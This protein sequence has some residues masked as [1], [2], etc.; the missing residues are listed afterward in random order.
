M[1]ILQATDCYPPPLLG[2]RDVHV[3]MLTHELARRGHDVEVV[4]LSGRAGARVESDGDV[5]V[6]RV[7][8]WSRALSRFYEDPSRIFHP[9]VPDPGLVLPLARLIRQRRPD[10]V[11]A[12]SWIL[13]S[14]LP[15]L[16][17]T[18]TRLVVT[19]HDYGLVCA[20][21]SF[22][23]KGGVCEGPSYPKC[24]ACA[25]GQYGAVRSAAITT[26]L[27]IMHRSHRRVDRYIAVSTPVAQACHALIA[28]H[29]HAIEVIPPFMSDDSFPFAD[30]SRPSFVPP[31][32]DYI[33][34][35]GALGPH[36]GV[37]VLLDAW[38]GSG[39]AV[40]LVLVG[41]HRQDTPRRFPAGVHVVE[42]VPHDDVLRVWAHC[43][44]AVVPS[45]W[46]EPFGLV[47][48]EAMAAGRSVVASAVGALPD[49]LHNGKAG[50]LVPPGDVG[51][52]RDTLLQ[53]LS[54]PERRARLGEAAHRRAADYSA[55]AI[56]PQIEDV[57]RAAL[58]GPPQFPAKALAGLAR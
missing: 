52:L 30:S 12:H 32:G 6:H 50:V 35:A 53:L 21:T 17:S 14:L 49:L 46:P 56:V 18:G 42:N 19:M 15:L 57:Y 2:G 27:S 37:D 43:A 7:A 13:H 8:G 54:D 33:M 28:N 40:P 20:K 5:P 26:G 48:L 11:H 47:A 25:T 24:L 16:P 3:Q 34:F 51:A 41:L 4:T 39:R 9:T 58:A 44:I 36:K 10:V 1:R 31:T 55:S 38:C 23:F 45:R 22:V 29:Q